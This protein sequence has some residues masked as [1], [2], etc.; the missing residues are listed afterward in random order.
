MQYRHTTRRGLLAAAAGAVL[1]PRP[2]APR[3]I[4][5]SRDAV[6]WPEGDRPLVGPEEVLMIHLSADLLMVNREPGDR[7]VTMRL[8]EMTGDALALDIDGSQGWTRAH[9][10]GELRRLLALVESDAPLVDTQETAT[11]VQVNLAPHTAKVLGW[12]FWT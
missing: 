10:A 4:L 9:F 7:W 2:L 3:Q 11:C 12:E 5:A 1:L 6:P 8:D